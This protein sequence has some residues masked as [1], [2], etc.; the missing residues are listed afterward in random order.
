MPGGAFKKGTA[1][2]DE[3]REMFVSGKIDWNIKPRQIA[4]M[5]ATIKSKFNGTQ[6]RT[7]VKRVRDEAKAMLLDK[8][9]SNGK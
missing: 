7:G 2:A 1:E 5:F 6:I 3:L 9:Q 4:D 8:L